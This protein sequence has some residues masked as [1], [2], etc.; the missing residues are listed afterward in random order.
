[1]PCALM[2][3]SRVRTSKQKEFLIGPNHEN[4]GSD[5]EGNAER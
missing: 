2:Y 5:I 3:T 4:P 1:M